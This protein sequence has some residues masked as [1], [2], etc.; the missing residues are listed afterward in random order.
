MPS[1][2]VHQLLVT[3]SEVLDDDSGGLYE[4][5]LSSIANPL[6]RIKAFV[7]Q[8]ESGALDTPAPK[9]EAVSDRDMQEI[10]RNMSLF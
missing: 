9:K 5:L 8:V 4:A 7:T 3:T 1:H 2:Q 6:E 10:L